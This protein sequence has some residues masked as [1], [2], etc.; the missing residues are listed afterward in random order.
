LELALNSGAFAN[1]DAFLHRE[2]LAGSDIR[3]TGTNE[4]ANREAGEPRHA[5][6]HQGASVWWTWTAPASGQVHL[7]TLGSD[8]DTV[9]AVYTGNQISSLNE[10]TAN[11]DGAHPDAGLTSEVG[12]NAQIG[13]TYQIAVD[14]YAS[15][16]GNI[17][18]NLKQIAD[19]ATRFRL[20]NFSVRAVGGSADRS[21][22]LGFSSRGTSNRS[23]VMRAVGPG[24]TDFGV[25]GVLGNPAIELLKEVQGQNVTLD[26]NDDWGGTIALRSA[27][28]TIGAFPLTHDSVDAGL[29]HEVA[30]EAHTL[31]VSGD[32]EPGVVLN[33]VYELNTPDTETEFSNISVR[34]FVG[35]GDE[36]LILGFVLQGDTPRELLIRGVGPTLETYRVSDVLPNPRVRVMNDRDEVIAANESWGGPAS[37]LNPVFNQVSAFSLAVDSDDSATTLVLEPGVYSVIVDSPT[38]QTGNALV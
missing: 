15:A 3:V 10:V 21:L 37:G 5:G 18:L 34:N 4:F 36:V 14:G 35:N 22:I 2:P 17:T 32:D 27:F 38:A 19:D 28:Q 11:D 12:F 30:T 31:I 9:L 23:L 8:F 6:Y 29:I 25:P 13:R 33:E 24:L 16:T 7:S 1:N 26:R 20:T